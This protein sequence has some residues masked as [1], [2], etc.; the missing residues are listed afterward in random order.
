MSELV[1]GCDEREKIVSNG[2]KHLS[3]RGKEIF[4]IR[5]VPTKILRET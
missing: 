3:V 4:R 1:F 2:E 5:E